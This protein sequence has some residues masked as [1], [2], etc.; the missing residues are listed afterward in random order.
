[1]RHIVLAGAIAA[2]AALPAQAQEFYA[3]KTMTIIVS[4]GA[5]GSSYQLAQAFSR[6]MPKYIPGQPTIIVKAMPGAG[7]LLATNFLHNIAPKDG[8]TIGTINNSIPLHQ[9][10]GGQ[11]VHFD[12]RKFHWLGSTGTYNSVAYVWHTAGIKTF[13]DLTEKEVILG[14]TGIGSSI[15]IYP[16]VMNNL[17]GT[18]FKIVLG[19]K[20]T[21]EIDLAMERGEVQARTGSYTALASEHPDWL[22]DNKV[23]IVAQIGGK[24]DPLIPDIPLMDDFA[25]TDE[26]RQIIKLI[27]SPIALGRPYLTPPEVPAERVAL[28]RKALA[29][30]LRDPG[31]LAEA[32]KMDIEIDTVSAEEITQIVHDTIN[33]PAKVIAAAKGFMGP[34]E[35]AR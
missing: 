14:G 17:L 4:T 5:G 32:K 9:A 8:T 28:L 6:H 26:A 1:M 12:A 22:K 24:R 15:V 19:Y 33:A 11:G 23:V 25:T 21:V 35:E 18:K 2:A 13:K 29:A 34:A 16:T 20:S 30:A 7:N 3:G 27:S 10:L 31:F